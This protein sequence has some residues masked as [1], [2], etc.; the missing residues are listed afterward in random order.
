MN[1]LQ[2]LEDFVEQYADWEWKSSAEFVVYNSP[3]NRFRI[4]VENP[5]MAT[6]SEGFI[7]LWR[8]D[9]LAEV[10]IS[11][12]CEDAREFAQALLKS[13]F[14]HLSPHETMHIIDA[15]EADLR[16]WD[17]ERRAAGFTGEEPLRC[18]H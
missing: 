14:Y 3:H 8:Q 9:K 11:A 18:P 10:G 7:G 6:V 12:D 13:M 15:L 17:D 2:P 16:Q 1:N 5:D 4:T